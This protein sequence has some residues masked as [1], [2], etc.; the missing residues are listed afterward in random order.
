M[1]WR[2]LYNSIVFLN[3]FKTIG[4]S[5]AYFN[6]VPGIFSIK[7]FSSANETENWKQNRYIMEK[8]CDIDEKRPKILT[9]VKAFFY[10]NGLN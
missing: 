3:L 7:I 4:Y 2:C 1:K 9:Y 8:S 6:V 10:N 5:C